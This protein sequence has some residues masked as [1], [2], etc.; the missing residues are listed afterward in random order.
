MVWY[1]AMMTWPTG[2]DGACLSLVYDT[3]SCQSCHPITSP[4]NNSTTTQ[5]STYFSS[6]NM[7][8][9]NSRTFQSSSGLNT[10]TRP[11]PKRSGG[12]YPS[13]QQVCWN[14]SGLLLMKTDLLQLRST[15]WS[16]LTSPCLKNSRL[17]GWTITCGFKPSS[18]M[19]SW[20]DSEDKNQ[21]ILIRGFFGGSLE[22]G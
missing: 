5:Q 3:M 20:R 15:T 17:L 21:L 13:G 1:G 19:K 12:D 14:K 7:P 4:L 11:S 2:H 10:I 22:W 9:L 16:S 18:T 6:L 8:I